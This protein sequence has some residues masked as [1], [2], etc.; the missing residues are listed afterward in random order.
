MKVGIQPN[1]L[2]TLGDEE[3]EVP[4]CEKNGVEYAEGQVANDGIAVVSNPSLKIGCLTTDQLKIRNPRCLQW[5][6][7]SKIA[8]PLWKRTA[9]PTHQK[10][11]SHF[12]HRRPVVMKSETT[13]DK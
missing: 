12:A 6:D 7:A 9:R 13:V 4:V 2:V 3:E 1:M 10:Y 8:F 11:T 5:N